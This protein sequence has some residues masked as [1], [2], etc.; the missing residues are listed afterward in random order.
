M[1]AYENGS[2][3]YFATPAISLVYAYHASLKQITGSSPSLDE[4]Y[5]LHR[6][7]SQRIKAIADQLG[8]K[9]VPM[10]PEHAANGMTAVSDECFC[11]SSFLHGQDTP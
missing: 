6:Q 1:K 11:L 3:A 7:V 5:R 10:D 4:R 8:L 2:P 9:Q